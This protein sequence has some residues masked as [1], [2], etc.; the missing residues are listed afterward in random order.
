[1]KRSGFI[2]RRTPMPAGKGLARKTRLRS[3]R[4]TGKPTKAESQRLD[5]LTSGL[6]IC[7]W[8]N[9][10][11]GRPTAFFGGCDAHHVLIGGRRMGHHATLACCPWHHRG[12]KPYEQMTDRQATEAFG[13]SLAH[14][15]KPFHAMYGNDADLLALQEQLLSLDTVAQEAL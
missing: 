1:M 13:P 11:H 9:R 14:G 12:V 10:Q 3:G 5:K 15:S 2:Q 8:I 6:C 7:C 4:S